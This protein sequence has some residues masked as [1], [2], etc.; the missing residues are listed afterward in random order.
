MIRLISILFCL[1]GLQTVSAQLPAYYNG[2]STISVGQPLK[3]QLSSLITSTHTVFLTYTPGIW[4]LLSEADLDLND[5][6][7][8]L[9][10]YGYNDSDGN[11][12]NDRTRNV[13]LLQTGSSN[14]GVWNREHVYA[15][16]LGTPDLGTSGPGADGHHLRA[17][18]GEMNNTRGS[19][20][21]TT[22]SGNAHVVSGTKFY[23]GDEWKGDVARMMMYMYLRYPS[24]CIPTNVG[25][26]TITFSGF[27]Q[28]IDLFITW[29]EQDAVSDFERQRNEVIYQAQG[30]RNPFIDEPYFATRIWKLT[31]PL[32]LQEM[33]P[34]DPFYMYPNPCSETVHISYPTEINWEFTLTD[35]FGR[36]L[37]K[38]Q[39]TEEINL[40]EMDQGMYFMTFVTGQQTYS[41]RIIHH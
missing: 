39:E 26:P 10:I 1:I 11:S 9:L 23:P 18:D 30:N 19:F 5:P 13:N 22:G 3:D 34:V 36:V 15:K 31:T 32:D 16:S 7:K 8:V 12:E 24:Q 29:S 2:I 27:D 33:E 41:K 21:F 17:A 20:P 6:S 25:D 40:A 38:G 28:M 4:D 14:V 35:E 37:L